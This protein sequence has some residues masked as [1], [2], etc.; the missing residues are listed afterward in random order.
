[1]EDRESARYSQRALFFALLVS[2]L[3]PAISQTCA[4][5]QTILAKK[6]IIT[7]GGTNCAGIPICPTP[8]SSTSGNLPDITGNYQNNANCWYLFAFPPGCTFYIKFPFFWTQAGYDYVKVYRCDNAECNVFTEEIL[9]NSG[10]L[11][12]LLTFSSNIGFLK[13]TF[14]SDDSVLQAGISMQWSIQGTPTCFNCAAGTY[15]ATTGSATCTNCDAGTYSA[16]IGATTSNTC[17]QCVAGKY[18]TTTGAKVESACQ[19]CVAGKYSTSTGATTNSTCY[20]CGA[21]TYSMTLGATTC[22][23]CG[24]G[25]YGYMSSG[26]N[27]GLIGLYNNLNNLNNIDMPTLDQ[28]TT[29]GVN[30]WKMGNLGESC[31][32]ACG[33]SGLQCHSTKLLMKE[34]ISIYAYI[35]MVSPETVQIYE[36]A[37]SPF[38]EIPWTYPPPIFYRCWGQPFNAPACDAAH[39][40]RYRLCSCGSSPLT[41]TPSPFPGCRDCVANTYNFEVGSAVSCASCPDNSQSESGQAVCL[42]N[43]GYTPVGGTCMGCARGTYKEVTGSSPCIAC[44]EHASNGASANTMAMNCVCE[45]GWVGPNT[46]LGPCTQCLAPRYKF[47]Q[48]SSSCSVCPLN[49]GTQSDGLQGVTNCVCNTGFTGPNGGPCAVASC[50]AGQYMSGSCQACPLYTSSPTASTSVLSCVCNAGY[51]GPNGVACTACLAGKYKT[52]TGSAACSDCAANTYSTAVGLTT[53]TC[54][55]CISNSQSPIASTICVCNPGFTGTDGGTCTACAAGNYKTATG[56]AACTDCA[57]NTQSAVVASTAHT[58]CVCNPGYSGPDGG[59]CTECVAGTH[60]DIAGSAACTLCGVNLYSTSVAAVSAAACGACPG[61]SNSVPGSAGIEWCSCNAGYRQSPGHDECIQCS[62]GF[63]DNALN[64]YECS[65]C[66]GGLFSAAFGATGNE[67]CQPCSAGLFSDAGSADCDLCP[68]NSNSPQQSDSITDCTCNPGATGSDGATC[69]LCTAAKY[70]TATGSAACADCNVGKYSASTGA[71]SCTDCG[72]GKY[73]ALSSGV[74]S[75]LS[76]LSGSIAT[77]KLE[78]WTQAGYTLFK[79]GNAGQT[80]SSACSV[81]LLECHNFKIS[82]NETA[83]IYTSIGQMYPALALYEHQLSPCCQTRSLITGLARNCYWQGSYTSQCSAITASDLVRLCACG[84]SSPPAAQPTCTN[85]GAGKYSA[86]EGASVASTCT[87][88]AAGKYSASTGAAAESS[89]STC[90]A[91]SQSVVG[92]TAQASCVCNPGFTGTNGGTCT[93]CVAGKYKTAPGEAA[94]TDCAA[95][96]YSAVVGLTTNTCQS[97]PAYSGNALLAQI[98]ATACLCNLGYSGT[99]GATCTACVAGKYKT[100]IGDATCTDCGAGKYSATV[101]VSEAGTC[102]DCGA[103]KYSPETGASDSFSC[104]SCVAGKYATTAGGATAS[105]CVD[106]AAGKHSATVGAT[107]AATCLDCEAGTYSA[108]PGRV[109]ASACVACPANAQPK[110]TTNTTNTTTTA[111]GAAS[112]VCDAGYR[113]VVQ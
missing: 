45:T 48:G 72:A 101:G 4:L 51:S 79:M 32:T 66:G 31:T 70:K 24:A 104:I 64:R 23:N 52:A 15:K 37:T 16:S 39:S 95:N 93:A 80:C 105:V 113:R 56:S 22:T 46:G 109:A 65:Q 10:N 41:V 88:C 78:E 5:G 13:V 86:A 7:C 53:S 81:S 102:L 42:C 36:S 54:Q 26:I 12:S 6:A 107:E 60:K 50:A 90:P 25:K 14:N 96:T 57:A 100:V 59:T 28:W 84:S 30:Q 110:Y 87:D 69:V 17:L 19:N 27:S 75:G 63:Y 35:G 73:G 29:A 21:G 34:T 74:A 97:C 38:C 99:N 3:Q 61:N 11:D 98:Y 67:T 49:S 58:N 89:C 76:G 9:S 112:C 82:Q 68:G 71:T 40:S 92:S 43:K 106:C 108:L 111:S 18:L 85:C 103:G 94:C 55:A 20:A 47:Y 77:S 2:C 91:N 1:M 62:P 8:S 44:P 83:A 33:N